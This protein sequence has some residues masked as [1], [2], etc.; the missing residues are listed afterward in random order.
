MKKQLMIA[1]ISLFL[2][3]TGGH[4]CLA[5]W[6]SPGNLAGAHKHL[7]GYNNCLTCHALVQGI[8]ISACEGCH[9]KLMKRIRESKG[10]HASVKGD[11][12]SCHPDHKGEDYD[13]TLLNKKMF[14]HKMTGY[15]LQYGHKLSCEKCHK[16]EGTYLDLSSTACLA[17]HKDSHRQPEM[18][19]C[20]KCHNF[21]D[22]KEVVFDHGKNSEYK[23]TGKHSDVKCELCHPGYPEKK[24][25]KGPSGVYRGYKYKV[26]KYGKCDDCHFDVHKGELK[27]KRCEGCHV[28]SG[29]NEGV[30]DHN[31]PLVSDY[32]LS[33]KH[34]KVACEL[35]H[36][37]EKRSY[38]EGGKVIKR[39]AMKISSLKYHYC[40]DCHYDVHE[41]EFKK[42]GC[43][44]CHQLKNDWTNHT[45]RH[46]SEKYDGYKIEGRH[47][48][49]ACEKCH[50]RSKV[51]YEEFKKTKKALVGK[52]NL[53]KLNECGDCHYDVHNGE[54]E[55]HACDACHMLKNDWKE[56]TFRHESGE[57]SGYKIEGKHKGIACEKCHER[58]EIRYDEFKSKKKALVGKFKVFKLNECGDCH[59][60]DHKGKFKEIVNVKVVT[61]ANCHSVEDE[62]KDFNYK[63]RQD[64]QYHKY[65]PEGM[66]NES[67]CESCHMCD[68]EVFCITCC[69]N[70][71]G[72]PN[73]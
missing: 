10:F 28:T 16:E 8:N 52:F 54:F 2:L 46:E 51:R 19:D 30:F 45:F 38:R 20:L 47:K 68:T 25:T 62:W 67:I 13:M 27:S 24:R 70:K 11:C 69:I 55:K 9:E 22:W 34:K 43:S 53:S 32:Q 71:I 56:H 44:T 57:Y 73:R 60:A 35:C 23:L 14:D 41:G 50:A 7:E 15:E 48:D 29:W 65:N 3:F 63:H 31:N 17:C 36:P 4:K 40:S 72:L 26:L 42:Q 12:I 6:I 18:S 1:A 64:S 58:N 21:R 37:E 59:K 61:C 5:Q 66:I 39:S 49:V 33:G